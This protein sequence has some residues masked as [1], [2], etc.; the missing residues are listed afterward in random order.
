MDLGLQGRVIL[1]TGGANGIGAD[2]V[3]ACIR[4]KAIPVI[5]DRDRVALERVQAEL[6]GHEVRLGTVLIDL[7]DSHELSRAIESVGEEF[8]HIDGLV[9]NA[10]LNDRVGLENGDPERFVRSLEMNLIHYSVA[11]EGVLPWLKA[12]E[13]AIVNLS[14]KVAITG[15]GGTSG[16][17][18]AKGAILELT[19]FWA[20]EW[21]GFGVR[22]NAVV[23]AEVWTP[24][25]QRLLSDLPDPEAARSVVERR[26]PMGHRFT[27][28]QEVASAVMFLLSRSTRISGQFVHPDG[29]Y[30]HLDRAI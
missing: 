22:V 18:A 10:G 29:G 23:P 13:G 12:S 17:A 28:P 25:Y 4:E 16:Y 19:R 3:R 2:I 24:L 9:N 14:S 26:I 6:E 30:V 1:V 8:G 15:Q 5:L 27:I 11:A 21:A 20:A 7:L